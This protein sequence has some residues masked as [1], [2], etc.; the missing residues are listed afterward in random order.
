MT[1]KLSKLNILLPVLI[2]IIVLY[3]VSPLILKSEDFVTL[4]SIVLLLALFISGSFYTRAGSVVGIIFLLFIIS[5]AYLQ[6]I[7]TG[8]SYTVTI[9]FITLYVGIMSFS[10]WLFVIVNKKVVEPIRSRGSRTQEKE[11]FDVINDLEFLE[12]P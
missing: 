3:L 8:G 12:S 1:E 9:S 4:L 5:T 11:I 2:S 10:T 7:S 6:S